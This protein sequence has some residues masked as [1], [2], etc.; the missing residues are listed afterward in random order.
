MGISILGHRRCTATNS[1][2]TII[3]NP[4]AA[5]TAQYSWHAITAPSAQSNSRFVMPHLRVHHSRLLGCGALLPA[6]PRKPDTT[7]SD[8]PAHS[9]CALDRV[10]YRSP[11][12]DMADCRSWLNFRSRS[13]N[14]IDRPCSKADPGIFRSGHLECSPPREPRHTRHTIRSDNA[15]ELARGSWAARMEEFDLSS[16]ALAL[17]FR[18]RRTHENRCP[19]NPERNILPGILSPLKLPQRRSRS[20]FLSHDI[21]KALRSFNGIGHNRRIFFLGHSRLLLRLV[22]VPKLLQHGLDRVLDRLHACRGGF[23]LVPILVV[24]NSHKLGQ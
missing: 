19:A 16:C 5:M 1:S 18:D 12:R 9:A 22:E 2:I 24:S 21:Y 10:R 13:R 4:T 20:A 3:G 14:T 11:R 17:L 15:G 8:G 7:E 23:R 6:H